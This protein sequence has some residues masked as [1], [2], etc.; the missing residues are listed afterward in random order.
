[1]A[2]EATIIDGPGVVGGLGLISTW[3]VLL[4]SEFLATGEPVDL[5]S[6][7]SKISA[8]S[9]AGVDAIADALYVFGTVLPSVG[10]AVTDAN[11][12]ISAIESPGKTGATEAAEAFAAVSS[13]NLASVGELRLIAIGKA[14]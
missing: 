13:T 11:V 14:L 2:A 8:L 4:D 5:T 1:M 12:L 9:I 6:V 3:E 7:Y 10:T